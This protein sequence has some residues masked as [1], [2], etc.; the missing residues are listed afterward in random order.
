MISEKIRMLREQNGMTQK[1]LAKKIGSTRVT[2]NSW[3]M[4]TSVPTT[5]FVVELA[6]VFR[7]SADYLLGLENEEKISIE[8]LD[9]EERELLFKLLHQF[10]RRRLSEA[11]NN[12]Q[13]ALEQRG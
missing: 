5:Q 12:Q 6:N 2:V 3:E 11:A 8:K 1:Y 9:T 13:E 4:G 10:E 7:V